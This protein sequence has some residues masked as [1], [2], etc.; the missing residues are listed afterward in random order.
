MPFVAPSVTTYFFS[1]RASQYR[2]CCVQLQSWK[3]TP[4]QL[5]DTWLGQ[6]KLDDL[7]TT[8][9]RYCQEFFFDEL[10][11][12][13]LI[14][15]NS[16]NLVAS[17][18]DSIRESFHDHLGSQTVIATH[19]LHNVGKVGVGSYPKSIIITLRGIHLSDCKNTAMT[20]HSVLCMLP[21]FFNS[22]PSAHL[23]VEMMDS[24]GMYALSYRNFVTAKSQ[25]S[26][27]LFWPTTKSIVV[28]WVGTIPSRYI[29]NEPCK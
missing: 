18:V 4:S 20:L 22:S 3:H 19:T 11:R 21:S 27:K 6:Q 25:R 13:A 10:L 23:K 9:S 28:Y 15:C 29:H 8:V 17:V 2:F 12:D 5:P 26:R 1:T 14:V 16:C 7:S 24:E